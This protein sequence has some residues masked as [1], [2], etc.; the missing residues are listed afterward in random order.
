MSVVQYS[1]VV[2]S[3]AIA[4]HVT[5]ASV[6]HSQQKWKH[7]SLANTFC[8]TRLFKMRP[9]FQALL[10]LTDVW[11]EYLCHGSDSPVQ[12]D[13]S[14]AQLHHRRKEVHVTGGLIYLPATWDLPWP[15]QDS[16]DP[17]PSLPVGGLPCYSEK[18]INKSTGLVIQKCMSEYFIS[19]QDLDDN[20]GTEIFPQDRPL[21]DIKEHL[22]ASSKSLPA[23]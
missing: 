22:R 5:I 10:V 17:D 1:G 2:E 15:A 4:G 23:L 16:R 12:R 7:T 21:A 18:H 3:I 19:Q 8:S 13:G 11:K 6:S 20:K 14:S 9:R